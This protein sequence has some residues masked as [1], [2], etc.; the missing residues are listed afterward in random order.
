MVKGVQRFVR[1]LIQFGGLKI[2]IIII[3]IIIT[4]ANIIIYHPSI[5][6]FRLKVHTYS[7]IP[8]LVHS[9]SS[10]KSVFKL[11]FYIYANGG[12]LALHTAAVRQ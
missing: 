4:I 10:W 6:H 2:P 11:R 5:I 1:V 8:L 9:Y 3:I 7:S 12:L